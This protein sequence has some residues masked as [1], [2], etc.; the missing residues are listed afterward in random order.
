MVRHRS[1]DVRPGVPRCVIVAVALAAASTLILEIALT[2]V[3]AVT[4]FYHFAFLTVS[5]ALLGFGAS[6]SALTAFP[7]LGRGGPRT[8]GLLAASQGLTTVGAYAVII[9]LPF[10]SFAIAWDR[11]QIA[12]LA[13]YYVVLAVPFFFG[14]AVIGAMLADADRA[15]RP[16]SHRV[17]G[18]S[19]LGSG[20][21]CALA[22]VA[23]DLVGATGAVLLAAGTAMFGAVLFSVVSPGHWWEPASS[24]VLA[25]AFLA[26]A[27]APA[28]VLQL[29]I[30]PYK[31]LS[32][33]LRYPGAAVVATNWDGGTRVDHVISEGIRSLPGLSLTYRGAPPPQDGVT[34]DADDLSAVPLVAPEDADFA[35]RMLG[36]LP[37]RL[38]PGADVLVLEPRGGLDV[39]VALAGDAASVVAVEPHGDAIAAVRRR[40]GNIYD[41]PRVQLV[42]AEARTFVDRESERF[43]VVDLALTTPYRPVSSGAYS[44]GEDYRMT[45]EAFVAYLERLD[46]GGVLA[47]MRWAQT[48][49]S[50]ETRLIATAAEAVRRL[51]ASPAD[52]IVALR[53]YANVLVLASL[54]GFGSGDLATLRSFAEELRFDVVAAPDLEPGETNRFNVMAVDPYAGLAEA[55]LSDATPEAVYTGSTF[56]IAP[57][58]DDRPFFGHYFK[59]AQAGDLLDRLGHTW[60]PFGGAGYF[61]LVAFL[62]L[63]A[64]AAE[65]LIV[66][67]L[68][69]HRNAP[70]GRRP[71]RWTVGYFGLLGA[72]FLLVEIPLVQRYIL[73]IG[74]PSTA[75]AVVLFGI[76]VP[77]GLGSLLSRRIPW[78]RGA[79]VL[80]V[81]AFAYPAIVD[82]AT[83]LLLPWPPQLRIVAGALLIAPL[84]FLMGIMFPWG[85]SHLEGTAR[86]LIP[87]AWGI[88]GVVSV[89]A[90]AAAAL[91]ALS[92]GFSVVIWLGA[93]CY[94]IAAA[95]TRPAQSSSPPV[96]GT[97]ITGPRLRP[98][99]SPD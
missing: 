94:A 69:A 14:G 72:G 79:V 36:A 91:L 92:F 90:A 48:P 21:G 52:S 8:W 58:T 38:R 61:V 63:S 87:W 40:P 27:A 53:S 41:D 82:A 76:L 86:Q 20:L 1:S 29:R 49:P 46:D 45:V 12:Y 22:V 95:L 9:W 26:G 97:N 56:E 50:E 25:L 44:L 32:G 17:Y 34:F 24:I 77:S 57:A 30:S 83:P 19:L 65:I 2:R 74:R 78:R 18:A 3:F 35:T 98:S 68:H 51:G 37:F 23:I 11:I 33:A 5:M 96:N 67:P 7:R 62:V 84:G 28:G 15:G 75:F 81:L 60:Q 10:D 66:A 59:W 16:A 6:G 64:V 80:A 85:I 4:Q 43:D 89:I 39:L 71:R 54:D 42:A 70:A 13:I 93:G 88:N 99:I 47:A 31:D 73:L 55:V